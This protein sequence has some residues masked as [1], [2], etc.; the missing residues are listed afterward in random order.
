MKLTERTGQLL[1]ILYIKPEF[2]ESTKYDILR[3]AYEH[4]HNKVITR[5]RFLPWFVYP[6]N[7]YVILVPPKKIKHGRVDEKYLNKVLNIFKAECHV[8]LCVSIFDNSFT[9]HGLPGGISMSY[10]EKASFVT[11]QVTEFSWKI[12]KCRSSDFDKNQLIDHL[13]WH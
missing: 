8:I 3:F 5:Q 11:K 7:V 2:I 4:N 12:L 10:I 6:D 13:D 1:D 9:M